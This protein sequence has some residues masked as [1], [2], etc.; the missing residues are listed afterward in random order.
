MSTE[1]V[2][3]IIEG[4]KY[5]STGLV[6][7]VVQD[8]TPLRPLMVGYMDRAAVQA[9]CDIGHVIFFSRSRQRPA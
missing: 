5:D 4:I 3:E 9:T 7:A 6:P 2:Q 8:A 1:K